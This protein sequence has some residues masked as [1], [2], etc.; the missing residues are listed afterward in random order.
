MIQVVVLCK[1]PVP[2]KVKT[3][4][5]SK[6]TPEQAADIHA[7]MAN[8]T[9]RKIENLFPDVWLAADDLAHP[10]FASFDLKIVEQ[11]QGT[12]GERLK[13]LLLKRYQDGNG[14]TLF[15]G[16]DS[17]HMPESRLKLAVQ[18]L[19][20]SDIVIGPVEDGGYDL[21]ALTGA[22][23]EIFDDIDWGSSKVLSQT[24]ER[25][26]SADLRTS[27]LDVSFDVDV[28]ADLKRSYQAGWNEAEWIKAD[29]PDPY[30]RS[31]SAIKQSFTLIDEAIESWIM[32]LQ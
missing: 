4:L 28:P 18:A 13:R 19:K 9:I 1:A 7:A 17:P 27:C 21:I 2:G 29:I 20:E 23:Q 15:L 6:F 32:E 31:S 22:Y 14:A 10:F 3:R 26:K 16:T 24:I 8:T 12:L 25:A 30:G 11:G 5:L